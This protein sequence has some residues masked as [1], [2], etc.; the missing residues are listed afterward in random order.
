MSSEQLLT[1]PEVALR[2]RVHPETIRRWL[3]TQ[4]L[5]GFRVGEDRAGW[6]V[7]EAEL[8]KFIAQKQ[9]VDGIEERGNGEA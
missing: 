7:P 5:R 4:K 1:V 2:L 3:R 8:A 9:G 6:R